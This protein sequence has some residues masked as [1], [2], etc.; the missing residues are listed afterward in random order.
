MRKIKIYAFLNGWEGGAPGASE[1][2]K[3]LNESSSGPVFK[4]NFINYARIFDFP[5]ANLNLTGKT[6]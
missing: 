5:E 1:A 2:S 3:N 6:S 4:K